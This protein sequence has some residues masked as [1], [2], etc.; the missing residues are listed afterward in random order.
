MLFISAI[1]LKSHKLKMAIFFQKWFY[2]NDEFRGPDSWALARNRSTSSTLS[3][4]WRHGGEGYE[5][6]LFFERCYFS[7]IFFNSLHL[8]IRIR[9]NVKCIGISR[10]R[11]SERFLDPPPLLLSILYMTKLV[12]IWYCL[13]LG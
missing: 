6:Y 8:I 3:T 2:F 9:S 13:G 11:P 10:V 4:T 1:R 7:S 12:F 5:M